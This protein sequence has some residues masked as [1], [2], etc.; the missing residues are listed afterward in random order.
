MNKPITL[1]IAASIVMLLTVEACSSAFAQ[2]QPVLPASEIRISSPADGAVFKAPANI[3][4][5]IE[6][7]DV[8]N[9]GHVIRLF[10]GTRLVHS[11]VLD[12]LVPKRDTLVPFNLDFPWRHVRPGHHVLIATIDN[13]SSD[14]VNVVVKTRRASHH[15]LR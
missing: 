1:H 11:V 9:I 15:S 2:A 7:A 14:P 5:Q 10:D 3:P 12:P 13:T 8:P 4:V 6:G